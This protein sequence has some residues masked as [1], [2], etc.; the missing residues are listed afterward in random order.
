[1]ED[2]TAGHQPHQEAMVVLHQAVMVVLHQAAMAV[3]HQKAGG[4][5]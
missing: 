4:K 3:A 2:Q 5:Q 1:M